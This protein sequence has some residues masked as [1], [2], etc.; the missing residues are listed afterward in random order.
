MCAT[1]EALV[2]GVDADGATVEWDGRRR[3]AMSLLVPDVRAGD[4][5]LVGLGMILG[6]APE[7]TT[8]R[9]SP[10]STPGRNPR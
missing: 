9:T 3:R 10:E 4:R 1:V 7:A 8:T 6:R 2:V 5:V